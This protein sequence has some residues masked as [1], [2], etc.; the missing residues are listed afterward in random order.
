MRGTG[1]GHRGQVV[2]VQV[3]WRSCRAA[4]R[5]IQ[6]KQI[7]RL[8]RMLSVHEFVAAGTSP[9]RISRSQMELPAGARH[10]NSSV[11]GACPAISQIHSEVHP[12]L[13]VFAFALASSPL[14]F[15]IVSVFFNVH[16]PFIH[17]GFTFIRF[18]FCAPAR[19]VTF[20]PLPFSLTRFDFS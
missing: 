20:L 12:Q 10:G 1:V 18:W 15:I 13:W 11:V 19:H 3:N 14:I 6:L 16:F 4:V 17:F 7:V 8:H 5:T 9:E 2:T